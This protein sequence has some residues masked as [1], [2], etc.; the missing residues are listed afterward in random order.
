MRP[1]DHKLAALRS[2]EVLRVLPTRQLRRLVPLV[3]EVILGPGAVL[4][5]QGDL[6]RHAYFIQSGS[7]GIEVDD[8]RV[9]TVGAGSV[10]GERTAI[11]H[12]LA[13]A[14]VTTLEPTTVFAVD[15]RALLGTAAG[16]TA[17]AELLGELA[18]ERTNAA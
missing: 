11:D 1:K 12:G 2:I 13:N 9:A 6:N 14:T 3:D 4:I 8:A 18:S 5:R 15:H 17:F 7:V 10:V 16:T